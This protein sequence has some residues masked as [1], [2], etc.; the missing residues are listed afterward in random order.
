MKG[1]GIIRYYFTHDIYN[2]LRLSDV[3][4]KELIKI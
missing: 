2:I 1:L 3:I 4:E